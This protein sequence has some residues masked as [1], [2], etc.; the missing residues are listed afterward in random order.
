MPPERPDRYEAGTP[1]TPGIAGLGAAARLLAE[2]GDDLRAE[3]RRLAR[4]L[5]EGL[6]ELGF[7]VLGP[8]PAEPRVPVVSVTHPLLEPEAFAFE[9]DRRFGIAVRAGLHCAPWAHRTLGTLETGAV[10]F[11]V[12][13]GVT[14][15]DIAFT[16]DAARS[17]VGEATV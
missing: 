8:G 16:L 1:N 11:S 17:L 4:L 9:L 12:G 5:H 14:E 6:L 15:T 10:R 2:Q 3:E 7:R 13:Y